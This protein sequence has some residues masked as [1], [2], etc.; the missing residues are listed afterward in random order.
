MNIRDMKK[1]FQNQISFN[2]KGATLQWLQPFDKAVAY[3][4]QNKIIYVNPDHKMFEGL[5]DKQKIAAVLGVIAHEC[6]HL[7]VT[8]FKNELDFC[9]AT[10]MSVVEQRLFHEFLNVLED[11]NI[12]FQARDNLMG[13]MLKA[14]YFVVGHSYNT[15]KP[16][17]VDR[18]GNELKITDV[19][20]YEE[21]LRALIQ[22]GDGGFVKG[23]FVSSKAKTYYEKILPKVDEYICSKDLNRVE[24]GYEIFQELKDLWEPITHEIEAIK[25]LSEMLRELGK[26]IG[27][28]GK[29]NGENAN[30]SNGSDAASSDSKPSNSNNSSNSESSD[31]DEFTKKLAQRRKEAVKEASNSTSG[32]SEEH[33][34]SSNNTSENAENTSSNSDEKSSKD[35]TK[36]NASEANSKDKQSGDDCKEKVNGTDNNGSS[37]NTNNNDANNESNKDEGNTSNSDSNKASD[38][39]NDDGSN[40]D[41]NVENTNTPNNVADDNIDTSTN[42]NA[43]QIN[44]NKSGEIEKGENSFEDRSIDL[45]TILS[46]EEINLLEKKI[47]SFGEPPKRS[48]ECNWSKV[49]KNLNNGHFKSRSLRIRNNNIIGSESLKRGYELIVSS[50]YNQITKITN[51]FKK[52]IRDDIKKRNYSQ[53]GKL[54]VSRVIRPIKTA[55]VFSKSPTNKDKNNVA[56][57]VLVDQSGS[58]SGQK[59]QYAKETA[60]ILAE[61]CSKIKYPLSVMGYCESS[62]DSEHFHYMRFEKKP[63]PI[64]KYALMSIGASGCNFDGYAIYFMTELMKKRKESHKIMFVITDG[65]P[66]ANKGTVEDAI[67]A[68]KNAKKKGIIVIGIGIG[69]AS[70]TQTE[71]LK[72]IYGKD[73]IDVRDPSSLPDLL[74]QTLKR[75]VKQW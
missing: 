35:A 31:L 47:S 71:I 16:I 12:E 13:M 21:V 10:K 51:S 61:V 55:K 73:Y 6:M 62:Y 45:S 3:T 69:I 57:S 75:I 11:P 17:N 28:E 67:L 8:P 22:F 38:L 26:D 5:S 24:L 39:S 4:S 44:C 54:E 52:I 32:Q 48:E 59:N 18:N 27:S 66:N 33:S 19:E 1:Y 56:V 60:I 40:T 64:Q 42:N 49:E 46:T 65:Q 30:Q 23:H 36:A 53:D 72:N 9:E 68:V 34:D 20:P 74:P 43:P 2:V 14:L 15:S 70:N 58:M 29:S 50:R 7:L 41:G 25:A 63:K 37:S